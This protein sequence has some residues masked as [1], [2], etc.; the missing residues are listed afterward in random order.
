MKEEEKKKP[1]DIDQGLE[2]S[3]HQALG[4]IRQALT[5]HRTM[6]NTL[7]KAEEDTIRGGNLLLISEGFDIIEQQAY[8]VGTIIN[9]MRH[10]TAADADREAFGRVCDTI[11]AKDEAPP[12]VVHYDKPLREGAAPIP[13]SPVAFED[14]ARPAPHRIL[15]DYTAEELV[16]VH[17][18]LTERLIRC[19]KTYRHD[20]PD[21]YRTAANLF[22]HN[23]LE[24]MTGHLWI[25]PDPVKE[26][27]KTDGAAPI[28]IKRSSDLES[29]GGIIEMVDTTDSFSH[30]TVLGQRELLMRDKAVAELCDCLGTIIGEF[31]P[32]YD[33]T[34]WPESLETAQQLLNTI[35]RRPTPAV[36]D[37]E[38]DRLLKG[39]H[40]NEEKG[41]VDPKFLTPE[42]LYFRISA[43]WKMHTDLQDIVMD[44][45]KLS[46]ARDVYPKIKEALGMTD[47]KPDNPVETP[48]EPEPLHLNQR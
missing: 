31:A 35:I 28:P 5:T 38:V 12:I 16:L 14:K 46:R 11:E 29:E 26:C 44:P 7:A 18:M 36:I 47:P 32:K 8:T 1:I 6:A 9:A 25:M 42:N 45:G 23:V 20:D 15:Y 19:F 24:Q 33:G 43:L 39:H 10:G 22:A 13:V 48:K 30:I 2:D 37:D 34:R 27:F 21:R 41:A 3:A 40:E 17:E 4:V